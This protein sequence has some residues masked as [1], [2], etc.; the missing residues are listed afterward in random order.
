M[1]F[2]RLKPG[3][4]VKDDFTHTIRGMLGEETQLR[5]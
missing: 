2:Q 5:P 1:R 4:T 3:F